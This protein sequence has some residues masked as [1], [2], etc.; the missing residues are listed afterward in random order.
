MT[1]RNAIR[2]VLVVGISGAT[3]RVLEPMAAAGQLPNLS[4]LRA[5]GSAGVLRSIRA[6]GDK[7]FRPQ[8]AWPTLASG[9]RPERHGLVHFYAD[10]RDAKAPMLWEYFGRHGVK[11]GLFGWD[12]TWP[13]Q[14]LDGFVVPSHQGRDAQTWPPELRFIKSL[15]R[16]QQ[17]AERINARSSIAPLRKLRLVGTLINHGVG[18]RSFGRLGVWLAR[19]LATRNAEKR[20]IML[21]HAK[22]DL[23]ADIFLGLT[24]KYGTT[25]SAFTTFLADLASH[26]YWRY[27]E[28]DVFGEAASRASE[29]LR[30]AVADAYAHI[31][32]VIG[33]FVAAAPPDA[34]IAVVSEHGMAPEPLS[35]E[36]G[37]WRY[38]IRGDRVLDLT[39]LDSTV[40]ICPVA[41]W[42]AFRFAAD[43]ERQKDI[44]ARMQRILVEQ[45]G[46]PLFQVHFHQDDEVIVKFNLQRS[47]AAYAQG[48]L[49]KLTIKYGERVVPF[50]AVAKRLGRQRSAMH[51]AEAV[52][53]V[54]GPG[55]VAGG[56]LPSTASLLDFAP[57]L[58]HASGLPVPP[59]LDGAVLDIF[60]SPPVPQTSSP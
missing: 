26:R 11:A 8:V 14:P 23:N 51:E 43:R 48:D 44:A 5:Q 30:T 39:G 32:R 60:S 46:L 1:D 20:A 31:D 10:T 28:P 15:D 49:E 56:P 12:M 50:T 6:P 53:I 55:I 18:L 52:L 4:R 47:I 7:H 27:R 16:E 45:T 29:Q 13:P 41:R 33:R 34:V 54:R 35:A 2:P 21:R 9:V 24:R 57:T 40:E 38:V 22:L 3:W 25:F 17:S 19:L 59:N 42:I 37:P 36:V 58:L